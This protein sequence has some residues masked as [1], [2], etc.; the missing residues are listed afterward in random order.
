MMVERIFA[1]SLKLEWISLDESERL[2]AGT[3]G[4]RQSC[5]D[6]NSMFQ[7]FFTEMEQIADFRDFSAHVDR[8]KFQRFVLRLIDKGIYLSPSP[9][10]HSLSSVAHSDDDVEATVK[11]VAEVLDEMP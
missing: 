5:R 1:N 2:L 9:T 3:I 4:T 8:G 7:I 11:A 10:L 6:V